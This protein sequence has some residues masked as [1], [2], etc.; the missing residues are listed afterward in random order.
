MTSALDDNFYHQT[1]TPTGFWYKWEM[2]PESLI[3]LLEISSI[4]LTRTH[5]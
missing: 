3:Q 2:N 5:K 4:E 1:K